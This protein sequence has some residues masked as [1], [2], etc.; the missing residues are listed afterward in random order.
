MQLGVAAMLQGVIYIATGRKYIDEALKSAASLKA[1]SP[2]VHVTAFSDERISSPHIDGTVMIDGAARGPQAAAVVNP[3]KRIQAVNQSKG[4]LNKVYYMGR[5]PYER[6]LFL[7]SDTYV[8]AD[9][10]QLF[11]L[12]DRFDIAVAHA[13]HRRPRGPAEQKRFHEVPSGFVVMNTGVILFKKSER[14][15]AFFASWLRLCQEEYADCNDQAS[16]RVALYHSDL[17]MA[18]LPPEYNFR[19]RKRL[20]INGSLRILHGRHPDLQRVARRAG[21]MVGRGMVGPIVGR[22]RNLFQRVLALP[23]VIAHWPSRK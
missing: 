17:R 3:A 15:A 20:C 19:F 12:L 9:I 5:S 6:T 2:S 1:A 7:D 4:M 8:A 18:I 13:P 23:M 11:S 10:S 22:P 16:F 14:T 21:A